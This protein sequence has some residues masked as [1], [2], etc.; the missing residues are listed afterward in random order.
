[1]QSVHPKKLASFF[2]WQQKDSH[3]HYAGLPGIM[4]A[5]PVLPA[6]PLAHTQGAP[7]GVGAS[8]PVLRATPSR[9]PGVSPGCTRSFR[10]RKCRCAQNAWPLCVGQFVGRCMFPERSEGSLPRSGE[11]AGAAASPQGWRTVLHRAIHG[12]CEWPC[13]MVALTV[14][15]VSHTVIIKGE[16]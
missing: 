3:W 16:G 2:A 9:C 13:P 8:V 12:L 11:F 4:L 1:M 15:F 6:T 7:E 5:L 14:S 10:E